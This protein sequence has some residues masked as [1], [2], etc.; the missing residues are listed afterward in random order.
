MGL[1]HADRVWEQTPTTWSGTGSVELNGVPATP[2]GLVTFGN[3]VGNGNVCKFL[4]DDNA[5]NWEISEGTY[6]TGAPN[7]ITRTRVI[8]SS[9]SGAK[10][11]FATGI[12]DVLLVPSSNAIGEGGIEIKSAAFTVTSVD[13]QKLYYM[14]GGITASL[15]VPSSLGDGFRTFFTNV[16]TQIANVGT[17]TP[18]RPGES[19]ILFS[20]GSSYQAFK[21]PE[22]LA[23][24]VGASLTAVATL[25]LTSSGDFFHV[26]SGGAAVGGMNSR[27]IGYEVTLVLTSIT[28]VVHNPSLMIMDPRI[29]TTIPMIYGPGDALKMRAIAGGGFR[30]VG[31]SP[32]GM[33]AFAVYA[34][35]V[36]SLAAS[37][38][39]KIILDT[40]LFDTSSRFDTT[41]AT[42]RWTPNVPGLY[43]LGVQLRLGTPAASNTLVAY[44]YQNSV[45]I[46]Q[47]A[48]QHS[49]TGGFG[50]MGSGVQVITRMNGSTD[51]VEFFA[52]QDGGANKNLDSGSGVTY[53]YGSWLRP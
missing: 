30:M 10:V 14:S 28:T 40:K 47:N 12:K 1:V 43:L 52:Y 50:A 33:P 20:N 35:G 41:T 6:S 25:T 49:A 24:T 17:V 8:A 7:T 5:G 34:S 11:S 23:Y 51:F 21:I 26:Q 36:H 32:A 39:T 48:A 9:N 46:A 4:I 53:A 37:T 2:L 42:A 13:R 29:D 27:E 15:A 44:I 38:I 45:S 3:G 18:L 31:Y 16:G 19:A 22:R